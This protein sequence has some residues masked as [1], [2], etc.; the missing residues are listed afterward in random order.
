MTQALHN[1]WLNERDCAFTNVKNKDG[2]V[3]LRYV[4]EAKENDIDI[5]AM[6]NVASD[7][8]QKNGIEPDFEMKHPSYYK[9]FLNG[10]GFKEIEKDIEEAL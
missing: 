3:D 2:K 5:I 8:M 4:E 6:G 10:E 1:L 9:R 7:T